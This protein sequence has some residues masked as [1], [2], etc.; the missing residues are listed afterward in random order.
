MSLQAA[1]GAAGRRLLTG[2]P[3]WKECSSGGR[4]RGAGDG[5]TRRRRTLRVSGVSAHGGTWEPWPEDGSQPTPPRCQCY[6]MCPAPLFS[7]TTTALHLPGWS[8]LIKEA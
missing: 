3:R 1:H 4:V 7:L 6:D 8:G 2:P 5:E